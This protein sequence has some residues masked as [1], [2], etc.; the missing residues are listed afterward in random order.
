VC[1]SSKI[2]ILEFINLLR[3]FETRFKVSVFVFMLKIFKLQ[4]SSNWS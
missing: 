4:E 3:R 2:D 1:D